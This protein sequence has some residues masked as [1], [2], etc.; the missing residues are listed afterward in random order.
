MHLL[1]TGVD[2]FV[3]RR[4]ARTALAAGDRVS[5]TFVHTRPE[6]MPT[7]VSVYE[8]DLSDAAALARSVET[9]NPDAIV[10]LAGLAHVGESWKRMGDYFRV[11]VLGTERLLAAASGR[12]VVLASSA[13]VY[14]AVPEGEQPLR[15]ERE[16][17]PQTPYALTKAA[18]E[19]LALRHGAV[20]ARSFNLLGAGQ[21][22][23]FALPSFAA[24]LAEVARGERDPVL[25][26]G[27][28]SA[29]RDYLHVDDGAA[30]YRLLAA[31]GEAGA[32]Y[33]VASG[34]AVAIA[35]ALDRLRALSGVAVRLE[36]D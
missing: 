17:N 26:V 32:V 25:K 3:G 1:I 30:A 34:R 29:R 14:G 22:S 33:N 18:A 21:S 2:G 13:E 8:A 31:H 24:Q 36:R 4:L 10:H 28:L 12:R 20:V 9:A 19:R 6:G 11:N 5:G 35:D 16:P 7:G 23:L 15:E 27:N